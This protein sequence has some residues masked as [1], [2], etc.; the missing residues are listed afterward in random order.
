MVRPL[1]ILVVDDDEDNAASLGE[2][3]EIEGHRVTVVHSGEAAVNAYLNTAFDVAFMDVMMP[4]KNG[5]ESFLEIRKLRPQARVY[6]MTGYSVE[7][8]LHQ[9]MVNGAMGVLAKPIKI[10]K[11]L[12]SLGEIAP[13][14]IMLITG[15]APGYGGELKRM[16]DGAGLACDLVAEGGGLPQATADARKVLILDLNRP[17]INGV[18]IYAQMKREGRARPTIIVTSSS[19]QDQDAFASLSDVAV[20]GI[21]NKPFDPFALLGRLE[22]LAA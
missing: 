15:E 12:Q 19:S 17:L 20:T 6:M 14:G 9:A 8:L 2:L 1:H 21:L 3:F 7:Q 5:V 11:L 18:E 16:I 22:Q 4:G 10:D 13:S